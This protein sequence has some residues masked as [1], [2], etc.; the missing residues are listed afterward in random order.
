MPAIKEAKFI[1]MNGEFVPWKDAK[2]HVLT[3]ALHY[4]TA[5][6][7]GI[8]AYDTPR[9]GPAVFRFKEH[10]E[11]LYASAKILR[12]EIP[13][14]LTELM[15]IAL[16]LIR[17]NELRACYI[18]PL[19]YR[20]YYSIGVDPSECPV[21][22]VIAT[23]E[24]GAYLGEEALTQGVDV[25]VSTWN[26]AAPNTFPALAKATGNYLNGALVKQEAVL[27]GYKEG[28]ALNA[29]G[30]VSEG[31]GENLFLVKDGII[32]TSPLSAIIL[33][34]IT[35]NSVIQIARDLGYEV[36]E[37]FIPREMLYIADELFFTGT[38]A[39]ITPIRSVDKIPVG[40]GTRGP[41]TKHLQE[42]FFRVV[43]GEEERYLHW[44]TPIYR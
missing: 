32:Y 36:R 43:K 27:Y 25:M 12:M 23:W 28:I 30:Y 16:E 20:G 7:E 26:R 21:E 31:S 5:V 33:P 10:M 39:E 35:R 24:W 42:V 13:Y 37:E 2:I 14:T 8:R 29:L 40:S 18:R 4:G 3:H 15:D 1:W 41:I 22:V 6:F 38:A 9:L 11:R 17:K 19:V 44:L 34:G